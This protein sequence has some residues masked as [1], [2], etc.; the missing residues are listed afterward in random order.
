MK[1]TIV[2][3]LALFISLPIYAFAT[4][5][6]TKVD[7]G[8]NF[9]SEPSTNSYVFRM[10]PRG[11]EIHVVEQVNKYW[12]KVKV[13]DGTIGY[14]SANTKYTSFDGKVANYTVAKSSV[15]FRNTPKVDN[16]KIGYIKKGDRVNLLEVYNK[17]WLKVEYNG[18]TGYVSANYFD[19]DEPVRE[20]VEN[21]DIVQTALSYLGAFSYKFGAEPWNTDYKYS[22]CSAF[23]Q[24]VL[25]KHHGLELPRTSL[26]QSQSGVFVPKVDLQAGDL[27]FFDTKD[28]GVVNHVGIYIG[29]GEFVHSSPSNNVGISS[30]DSGYWAR[31][32]ETGRRVT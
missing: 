14:V 28:N 10:L 19:Y 2:M 1:K 5:Y 11:E 8:V 26:R 7:Y 20:P 15:N 13:Q 30:L 16:N 32:Y 31:K 17:Y 22:D 25:S 24:L 9:R 21:S 6:E 18:K 12:L 27:V 23:V 3:V 29:N 4:I